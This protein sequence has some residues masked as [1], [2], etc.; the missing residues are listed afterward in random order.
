MMISD[1]GTTFVG[2]ANQIKNLFASERIHTE[3]SRRGTEWRFII[4]RAPWY[5]GWLGAFDW[6]NENVHQESARTLSR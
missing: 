1:N 2:A 3:L 4:K 5:G 6:G